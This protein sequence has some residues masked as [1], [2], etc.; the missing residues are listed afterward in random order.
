VGTGTKPT[1]VPTHKQA[2]NLLREGIS[3]MITDGAISRKFS[4]KQKFWKGFKL[5]IFLLA[6]T[7]TVRVHERGK[8]IIDNS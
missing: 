3:N 4:K 8:P 7:Q 1:Q 2:N 6:G 5:Y